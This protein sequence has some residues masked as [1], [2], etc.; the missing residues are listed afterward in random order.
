MR[1]FA[2]ASLQR[3]TVGKWCVCLSTCAVFSEARSFSLITVIFSCRSLSSCSCFICNSCRRLFSSF[4][5]SRRSF[6]YFSLRRRISFSNFALRRRISPH[7]SVSVIQVDPTTSEF[8]RSLFFIFDTTFTSSPLATASSFR[9]T[10]FNDLLTVPLFACFPALRFFFEGSYELFELLSSADLPSAGFCFIKQSNS[11]RRESSDSL[12]AFASFS[13]CS[14]SSRAIRA[15]F[16]DVSCCCFAIFKLLFTFSCSSRT[17]RVCPF[18]F[19]C[20]CFDALDS[21]FKRSFSSRTK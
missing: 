11:D 21:L 10:T 14:F 12:A 16:S 5:A 9:S 17:S 15:S 13:H 6:L 19:S 8:K 7:A 2:L 20:C 18:N 3:W 1:S 4:S